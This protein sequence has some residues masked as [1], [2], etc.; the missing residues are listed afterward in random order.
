MTKR[1]KAQVNF[2]LPEKIVTSK[3]LSWSYGS[4]LWYAIDTQKLL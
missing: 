2:A 4:H 1:Y 3:A